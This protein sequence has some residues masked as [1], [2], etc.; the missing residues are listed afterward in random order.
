MSL[1]FVMLKIDQDRMTHGKDLYARYCEKPGGIP[2]FAFVSGDD[3]VVA[4]SDGPKGNVGHPY[5]PE[6]IAHFVT[7]L[8]AG[9][10]RLTPEQIAFVKEKLMADY[11]IG[12]AKAKAAREAREKAAK[13]KQQGKGG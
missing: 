6:E 13:E 4:T 3:K 12:E 9:K 1:D 5:K 8:E 10:K 11:E 7:M 2:W